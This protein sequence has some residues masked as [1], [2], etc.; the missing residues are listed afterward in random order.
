MRWLS[1][2]DRERPSVGIRKPSGVVG[3]GPHDAHYPGSLDALIA[4]G[5]DALDKAAQAIDDNGSPVD[6][7]RTPLLPPLLRPAKIICVGLN[8]RD[9]SAESGFVQPD[10]PTL[11]GRFA[12]SLVAHDAPIIRPLV[13]EQLD[14]E[15]EIAAI[16][17]V[18]GRHIAAADALAHVMGYSLFNDASVRDYQ[19]KAP[20]WTPGKNFDAT[21]AFG[22]EIVTSDELPPGV[23]GL[24]LVTTLAGE[25]MQRASTDDMV[26]DV[27]ALIAV[28]SAVM[29]LEPGDV[30]VT[31]TPAGVG[32]GRVPP[33]WM[34]DGEQVEVSVEGLGTLVN[35][36]RDER[37]I[38]NG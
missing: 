11:F 29:T 37:P 7:A 19:F 30:I 34:H 38:A 5:P 24:E 16:I 17:G 8:Y 18:G 20:Q 15:G 22:P 36:V 4:G 31:G 27:A 28:I 3:L 21:G 32:L 33:R 26:F 35:P 2:G 14:Y 13:S 23:C 1:Y 25:V 6:F 9:H 12:S 10:Y